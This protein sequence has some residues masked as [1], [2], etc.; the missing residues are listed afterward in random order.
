MAEQ[1]GESTPRQMFMFHFWT[2]FN[3]GEL[4]R[5][6][7]P[8][9][10]SFAGTAAA[11]R[12]KQQP[13]THF[14]QRQALRCRS[15]MCLTII[16]TTSGILWVQPAPPYPQKH[17]CFAAIMRSLSLT[18]PSTLL[19]TPSFSLAEQKKRRAQPS[20]R[21][22]S[23]RGVFFTPSSASLAGRPAWRCSRGASCRPWR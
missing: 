3:Q 20:G 2:I 14:L 22:T 18:A 21:F 10:L 4:K 13:V 9:E 5:S 7:V 12:A 6:P 19:K 8:L 16:Y 17:L 23:A 1:S 15:V 11:L